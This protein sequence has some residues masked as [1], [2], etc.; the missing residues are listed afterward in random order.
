MKKQKLIQG[1]A[2]HL[3]QK[4]FKE[5]KKLR[6]GDKRVRKFCELKSLSKNLIVFSVEDLT[7]RLQSFDFL[8]KE[9]QELDRNNFT[10][11]VD[12][13]TY[14]KVFFVYLSQSQEDIRKQIISVLDQKEIGTKNELDFFEYVNNSIKIVSKDRQTI[15]IETYQGT[16]DDDLKSIDGWIKTKKG[17]NVKKYAIQ[18]KMSDAG[19]AK[20]R[21]HISLLN[22]L[23]IIKYNMNKRPKPGECVRKIESAILELRERKKRTEL[24]FT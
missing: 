22:P 1:G 23:L 4:I 5:L 16:S 17:K 15:L 9:K 18:I 19:M 13:E 12:N 24:I 20:A 2:F 3:R 11:Y 6:Y 8:I 7:G 21:A 14:R 10:N